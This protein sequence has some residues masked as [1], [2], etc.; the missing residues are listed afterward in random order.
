MNTRIIKLESSEHL[1]DALHQARTVM[2]QG[3]VVGFP[4]ETVYGLAARADINQALINLSNV[5]KRHSDKPFT[6][7]LGNRD[8]ID[9]SC[10]YDHSLGRSNA[11]KS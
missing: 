6:L 10:T 11:F 4:T 1:D 2:N 3:G 7:H 8:D 5:K 9:C